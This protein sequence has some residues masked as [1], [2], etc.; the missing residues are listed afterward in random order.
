MQFGF[1]NV[2]LLYS[3]YRHVSAINVAVFMVKPTH[4]KYICILAL[5][6][7]KRGTCVAETCRWS[8]RIIK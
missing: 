8:P 5:S 1:M 7:L 3:D 2:I 6:T 4:Y